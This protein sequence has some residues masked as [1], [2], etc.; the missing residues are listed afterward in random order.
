MGKDTEPKSLDLQ[1][2]LPHA[3]YKRHRSAYQGQ[4]DPILLTN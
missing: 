4:Q 3:A 1:E 2:L